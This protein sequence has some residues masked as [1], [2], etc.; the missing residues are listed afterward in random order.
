MLSVKCKGCFRIFLYEARKKFHSDACFNAYYQMQRALASVQVW[1]SAIE[2]PY[3]SEMMVLPLEE[4]LKAALE[5][6]AERLGARWYRLGA[7]LVGGGTGE[8]RWFPP[9]LPGSS[10]Y[11]SIA[12]FERPLVPLPGEYLLVLFD[13]DFELLMPPQWKVTIGTFSPNLRWSSG[14]RVP[15]VK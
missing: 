12:P 6:L 1:S 7:P 10:A 2:Y 4:R 14:S 9:K 11:R 13:G 15:K 3:T 8:S 5:F